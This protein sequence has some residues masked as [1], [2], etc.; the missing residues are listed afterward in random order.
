MP[1]LGDL[2]K[3]KDRDV[4]NWTADYINAFHVNQPVNVELSEVIPLEYCNKSKLQQMR[5]FWMMTKDDICRRDYTILYSSLDSHEY[6]P[7]CIFPIMEFISSLVQVMKH[8]HAADIWGT[9]GE[10]K[11]E[12]VDLKVGYLGLAFCDSFLTYFTGLPSSIDKYPFWDTISDVVL[13]IA[14]HNTEFCEVYFDDI[15]AYFSKKGETGVPYIWLDYKPRK[16]APGTEDYQRTLPI[17]ATKTI[18]M[19]SYNPKEIFG[20]ELSYC[21]AAFWRA[22]ISD[23]YYEHLKSDSGLPSGC[24]I[25]MKRS[26]VFNLIT[27]HDRKK[28]IGPN[29]SMCLFRQQHC[30]C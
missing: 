1:S 26:K 17:K 20:I 24:R 16:F 23:K 9:Q 14:V 12:M 7:E 21:Y 27:V 8:T 19:G 13:G 15:I 25:V 3:Q 11:S 2:L 18:A 5:P 4:S 28:F 30:R 22:D 10:R 29:E 6:P